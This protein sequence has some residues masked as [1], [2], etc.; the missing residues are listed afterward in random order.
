[1]SFAETPEYCKLLDHF[2]AGCSEVEIVGVIEVM[3]EG[4]NA[5]GTARD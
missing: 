5:V 4:E 1:M 2:L 3:S